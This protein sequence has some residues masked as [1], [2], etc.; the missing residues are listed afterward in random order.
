MA[1]ARPVLV[2]F[3]RDLRVHDHPALAEA[4]ARPGSQVVPL[5]VIDPAL[6][7]RSRNRARFLMESLLDL[8]RSLIARGGG[9][10]IRWGDPATEAA[11][12]ARA[13]AC[14]EIWLTD[15]VSSYA[16]RR[17]SALEAEG[18]PP[19]AF[20]GHAIVEPGEVSPAGRDH[21]RVFSP[22]LRAWQ[23]HP[24]RAILRAPTKIRLPAT[25]DLG[26]RPDLARFPTDSPDL[27]PGGETPGRARL[28]SYALAGGSNY[29]TQR[30]TAGADGTSRLSPYLRFG[31][32]SAGEVA[33]ELVEAPALVR[34]LAWR[35][36]F[37]QL[38]AA[39]PAL[40]RTDLR[41]PPDG[42][43]ND[44]AGLEAWKTGRTG[45]P[46]VDAGMRQLMREGWM[47]G[48]ARMVAASLLTRRLE[49]DWREGRAHF[50][51]LLL[52]GDVA[53]DAGNWQWVA[54]TGTDPRRGR[55]LNPVRQARRFD[56]DGAYVR[57]Y[58][59]ELAEVA[60]PTLFAPWRNAS[61]LA[62]R[63]YPP[64]M[65]EVIDR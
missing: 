23:A 52:D 54:G 63:G 16:R 51:R 19:R 12:L 18:F 31:C 29:E 9:L 8:D 21:Y 6:L 36:F 20:A 25:L 17:T 48:R 41:P 26:P 14:E 34:Q 59:E 53:N 13:T 44:P 45:L 7:A 38:L 56:A 10:A 43:R 32:L 60:T 15:D 3:T 22:Y 2:L 62:E 37:A 33:R 35:D 11:A 1:S 5:F 42:W 64:P 4:C 24:T 28:K 55:V 49:I 58:V 57:R 30:N 39:D 65:V 50:D 47:H 40:A 27:P 61:L 46:F